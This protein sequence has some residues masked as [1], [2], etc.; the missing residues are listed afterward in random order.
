MTTNEFT[1]PF[2]AKTL[3]EDRKEDGKVFTVRLNSFEQGMLFKACQILEQKKP[4]TVLKQLALIGYNVIHEEKTEA[5][6]QVVF[7]N[8]RNNKARGVVDFD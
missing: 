3:M 2:R 7:K 1:T 4:S 6:L 5:L 8:K